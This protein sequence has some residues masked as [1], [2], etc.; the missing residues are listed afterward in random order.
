MS[1]PASDYRWSPA[2]SHSNESDRTQREPSCCPTTERQ[3]MVIAAANQTA[4]SNTKP[5]QI[6]ILWIHVRKEQ[7]NSV[8]RDD[9]SH[10]LSHH[11][12]K[13]QKNSVNRDDGSHQLSHHVRKEQKN[14]VNRDDGSYQLS[15][16][17][18]QLFAATRSSGD[19]KLIRPFWWR[20]RHGCRNINNN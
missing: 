6:N 9:G 17:C 16:I 8:N 12:R 7:K 14:S 5:A 2:G 15:H 19:W 4:G 11:V 1:Y 13:E 10:Q 18:D 20:Q 3:Q